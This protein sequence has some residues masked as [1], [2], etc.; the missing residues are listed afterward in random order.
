MKFLKDLIFAGVNFYAGGVLAIV[1]VATIM[2]TGAFFD[3]WRSVLTDALL[4][5][6]LVYMAI[7]S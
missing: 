1:S 7:L 2:S 6:V 4:W 3:I 5:P